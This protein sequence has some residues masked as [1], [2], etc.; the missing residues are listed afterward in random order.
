MSIYVDDVLMTGRKE[1]IIAAVG[2]IEKEWAL[3]DPDLMAGVATMARN[4]K[5][6]KQV[7]DVGMVLLKYVNATINVGLQR[8]KVSGWGARGHLSVKRRDK[9]LEVLGHQLRNGGGPQERA[10]DPGLLR[11]SPGRRP[12]SLLWRS[13]RRRQS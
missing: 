9:V 4:M 8:T 7:V 2:C 3:S 12:S 13:L 6:P 11:Q 5:S 1:V 10:G